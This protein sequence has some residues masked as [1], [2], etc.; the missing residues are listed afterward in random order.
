[1]TKTNLTQKQID[2][3]SQ[4]YGDIIQMDKKMPSDLAG[5]LYWLYANCAQVD[6]VFKVNDDVY[7]N[8][9]NLAHFIQSL[10]ETYDDKH[11]YLVGTLKTQH[12]R[13]LF[14]S[15]ASIRGHYFFIYVLF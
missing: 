1:M 11:Q 6:F 10:A 12:H 7:V 5:L 3:E 13:S 4:T 2:K 15:S 14:S 9:F 8:V